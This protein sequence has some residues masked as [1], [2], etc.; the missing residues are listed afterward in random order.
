M[1][2]T[3]EKQT[4][5]LEMGDGKEQPSQFNDFQKVQGANLLMDGGQANL[6]DAHRN[7]KEVVN[8]NETITDNLVS[9]NERLTRIG[10][11]L[12]AMQSDVQIAKK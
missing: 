1:I 2:N 3:M 5:A 9:Q 8:L 6:D 4:H 12:T 7:L 11:D 10:E